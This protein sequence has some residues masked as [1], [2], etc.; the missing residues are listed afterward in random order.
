M[1]NDLFTEAVIRRLTR[2][3][4]QSACNL[5]YH[6]SVS[7]IFDIRI[8]S[9]LY[10]PQSTIDFMKKLKD[11]NS[12]LRIIKLFQKIKTCLTCRPDID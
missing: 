8:S 11:F 7:N 9:A 5:Q 12:A 2:R 1:L 4:L 3:I 10:L 6:I